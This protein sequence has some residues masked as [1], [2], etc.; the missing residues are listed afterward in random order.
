MNSAV[1]PFDSP[2]LQEC[3]SIARHSLTL[4][5]L[6]FDSP[7]MRCNLYFAIFYSI[8]KN[9]DRIKTYI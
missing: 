5:F 8:D 9:I 4:D 6:S 2:T 7:E 3:A 1:L